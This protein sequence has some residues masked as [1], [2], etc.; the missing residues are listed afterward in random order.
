MKAYNNEKTT[1][2]Y[3]KKISEVYF[4][5]ISISEEIEKTNN[6]KT[7][8]ICQ[9]VLNQKKIYIQS[10]KMKVVYYVEIQK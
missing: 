6:V 8:E 5:K 10:P 1:V 9:N 3:R 2:R 7:R 4:I